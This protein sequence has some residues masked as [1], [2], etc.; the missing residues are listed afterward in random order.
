M[1]KENY[2][3]INEKLY[4]SNLPPDGYNFQDTL[5]DGKRLLYILL[6]NCEQDYVQRFCSEICSLTNC[7]VKEDFIFLI[8]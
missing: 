6:R 1:E 8:C 5:Y 4:L 2:F 7:C 3:W